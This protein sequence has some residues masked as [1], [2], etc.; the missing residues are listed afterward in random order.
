MVVHLGK[1]GQ[2]IREKMILIQVT[3]IIFLLG[4]MG[5]AVYMTSCRVIE[6]NNQITYEK[7]LESADVLLGDRLKT[8][9]EMAQYIMANSTLQSELLMQQEEPDGIYMRQDKFW[10]LND[11]FAPYANSLSDVDSMYIYNNDGSLFYIQMGSGS[12]GLIKSDY[13]DLVRSEWYQKAVEQKGR[14]VFFAGDV[15][16]DKEN[17]FS[18]VKI[19]NTL[20]TRQKIGLLVLKIRDNYLDNIFMD[21]GN[22]TEKY[23]ISADDIDGT[24]IVYTT[25][26]EA[27]KEQIKNLLTGGGEAGEYVMTAFENDRTGWKMTHIIRKRE[28]LAMLYRIRNMIVL[29]IVATVV[30]AVFLTSIMSIQITKPLLQLKNAIIRVRHGERQIPDEFGDDEVGVIGNEFKKLIQEKIK[31]NEEVTEYALRQKEAELTLLQEQINPHFLY[32]TLDSIYWQAI[33]HEEAEIAE[34]TKAL[35]NTFRIS[36]NQGDKF[37]SVAKEIEFI[38]SYLAIQNMRFDN[39]FSN[40]ISVEEELMDYRIIKLILQ[41]FVENAIY[42]GLEPKIGNG[43]LKIEGYIQDD[44]VCFVIED[45]GVGMDPETSIRSGYGIR[46]VLERI[47]LQYGETYGVSFESTQGKGTKVTMRLPCEEE[48][49][50]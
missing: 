11:A 38:E 25:E 45:D 2:T 1:N 18:C 15:L 41:P 28:M 30:L 34:M 44:C 29:I 16:G 35:S 17:V 42:H 31:L 48:I 47:R 24:K 36:L 49:R 21:A 46:N 5:W 50:C 10:R 3:L 37:I 7:L 9:T 19:L 12:V 6:E 8:I 39:R 20:G 13:S 27:E 4:V 14:E 43:H 23:V 33:V 32:N 22:G 26:T 40:E